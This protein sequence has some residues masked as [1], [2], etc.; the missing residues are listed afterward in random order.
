MFDA[1][2]QCSATL[3]GA[4]SGPREARGIA[5]SEVSTIMKQT[6]NNPVMLAAD[7]SPGT[8]KTGNVDG[9]SVAVFNVDGQFYAV[10]ANCTHASGP[11][12]EGSIWGEIVT[13][14]WHTS[15]FNVRTGEVVSSPAERSLATYSV[16][17]ESGVITVNPVNDPVPASR[18]A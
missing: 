9:K 16:T 14:P 18:D 5:A 11:L 7:I 17:V 3:K 13:C 8:C 6:N 12:C 15:E 1:L 10:Q 4:I 2:F